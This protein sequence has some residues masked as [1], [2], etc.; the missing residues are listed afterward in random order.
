MRSPTSPHHQKY[1]LLFNKVA[2]SAIA[3]INPIIKSA[4]ALMKV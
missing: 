2:K 3:H 4:I 1:D